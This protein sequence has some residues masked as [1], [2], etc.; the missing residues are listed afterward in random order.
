[1]HNSNRM[2]PVLF[3]GNAKEELYLR[4]MTT[5]VKLVPVIK[6]DVGVCFSF[7][8]RKKRMR[9]ASGNESGGK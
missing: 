1:M 2:Q 6:V 8:K 4:E 9:K 3:K 5:A 7:T